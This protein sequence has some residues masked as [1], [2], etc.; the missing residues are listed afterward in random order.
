[1]ENGMVTLLSDFG[2]TDPYVGIMKGAI[3]QINPDLTVIDLTHQIPPQN[4]WAARFALMSAYAYFP[5]GTVHVAVVDPGVGSRRRAIALAF[6]A[7]PQQPAGFLVGPDN[8]LFCGVL[9]QVSVL[10][11]VELANSNYWRT[12]Q[13]SA[14]FHGRDI[15]APVGAH[16]A[17]GVP[18]LD[19]GP[20]L[21]AD[22]L[23]RLPIPAPTDQFVAH[24]RVI[25]GCIQ[26]IDHFGNLVTSIPASAVQGQSWMVQFDNQVLAGQRT[27]SDSTV[28]DLVALVGSHGW[29]EIAVNGGNAQQK[30]GLDWGHTVQVR[31]K[32][33]A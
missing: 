1:M 25:T 15:F 30:L 22:N 21:S 20:T 19:L 32:D 10:Q 26:A 5:V 9:S 8:G 13:P 11:A 27:Y 24:E 28:G 2:L 18:L 33:A 16:L 23:V 14:T 6:G 31:V 29:V 12:S 17:S 3:A 7:D 4:L